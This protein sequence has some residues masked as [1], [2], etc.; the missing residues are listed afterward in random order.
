[1]KRGDVVVIKADRFNTPRK[2]TRVLK[3]GR[4]QIGKQ[5]WYAD[6]LREPTEEEAKAFDLRE[7]A[8]KVTDDLKGWQWLLVE[9]EVTALED[10][11]QKLMSRLLAEAN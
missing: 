11:Y 10:V 4:I 2:V 1:M 3:D 7:R 9:D 8:A 5:Y 6:D